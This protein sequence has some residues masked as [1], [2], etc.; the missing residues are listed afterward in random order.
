MIYLD[1]HSTTPLDPI[2]FESMKPYFFERFGNASHGVHRFNWEA[3]A[4]VENARAQ[5]AE[6]IG[7]HE[8]EI[9]FTS[10]ATE[11][12]H[13]AILGLVPYLQSS[14][15]LK[16]LSI[17]IEHASLLGPLDHL[18]SQ[19]ITVEWVNT[20][21]DGRVD[22]ADLRSKLDDSVGLVSIAFANHE[23]G[24]VQDIAAISKAAHEVGALVHTDAVQAY[25]KIRFNVNDVGIDLMTM[26]A[27][28]IYGPKGVGALYV[29]RKK[30]KVELVPLFWGGNQERG[31]RAGTPNSPGIVGFGKA[32]SLANSL[33]EAETAKLKEMRDL[34]WSELRTHIPCLIRNGSEEHA[35]PNNLNVSIMGID[36]AG[37]FGRLKG[38]AV[39]NASACLTG[40]QDYSQVLTVLGVSKD[41]AKA[42]LRFGVG[43]FN[44]R[45]EIIAAAHEIGTIVKDLRR[46]EKEFAE[47]SG[48]DYD[49]LPPEKAQ[50][51]AMAVGAQ[52]TA[53]VTRL[54]R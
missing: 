13:L 45:E 39:S 38:V 24:T 22:L 30:P 12:N 51:T 23:I 50:K 47:Q 34:L 49:L 14:R 46:L 41:L 42:T 28:K 54:K 6:L 2:V 25:G 15:R 5:I 11:S 10:G 53:T 35:L 26:S 9:I 16:I 31:F 7:A 8:K 4:G 21:S 48:V 40:P 1:G 20:H 33:L 29:R 18:K 36:G 3:E 37:L 32:S 27:H 17:A 52:A 19:G 44:T 43:R